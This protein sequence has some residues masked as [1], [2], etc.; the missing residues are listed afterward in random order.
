M[1][2]RDISGV[3]GASGGMP[4]WE[5]SKYHSG[6]EGKEKTSVCSRPVLL[7][8]PG[9]C[10]LTFTLNSI[11]MRGGG[12]RQKIIV[13][14]EYH[15]HH[16]SNRMDYTIWVVT[17]WANEQA[18]NPLCHSLVIILNLK[19]NLKLFNLNNKTSFIKSFKCLP[20]VYTQPISLL[21]VIKLK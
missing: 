6:E 12:P 1:V 17:E 18:S 7:W 4:H 16:H 20:S 3:S 11:N 19:L 14:I 13:I 9:W 8:A 10:W 5:N 15:N 2:K 21:T